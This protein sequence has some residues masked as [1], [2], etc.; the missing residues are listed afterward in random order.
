MERRAVYPSKI[1]ALVIVCVIVS[2]CQQAKEHPPYDKIAAIKIPAI[3][4]LTSDQGFSRREDTLYYQAKKYSGYAYQ[5]Y[6]ARDTALLFGYVDGLEAGAIKKWYPNRQLQELR[7]YA[8]GKK[9]GVHTGWWENGNKKFEFT[10]VDDFYEGNFKEWNHTG[11]L[12]KD[13][14]YVHGQEQ[15]SEKLWWDDGNI[16]A[17]YVIDNGKKYGLVGLKICR[18][19]YDSSK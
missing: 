4:K 2:S 17:N 8:A 18:N 11:R 14:N 7:Y 15:G 10:I 12:I 3:Y 1:V 5:L 9:N 19:L 6:D 16:R 13:F